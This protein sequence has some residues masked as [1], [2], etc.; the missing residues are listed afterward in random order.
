MQTL[1][2]WLPLLPWRRLSF[3]TSHALCFQAREKST[4]GRS[5]LRTPS[6]KAGDELRDPHSQAKAEPHAH[7]SSS[8]LLIQRPLVSR[9]LLGNSLAPSAAQPSVK[10]QSR[11]RG[12][13]GPLSLHGA[14]GLLGKRGLEHLSCCSSGPSDR[15]PTALG[16]ASVE[17]PSLQLLSKEAWGLA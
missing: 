13:V 1:A 8:P 2:G 6:P 14:L 7:V 11:P 12:K 16:L 4:L 17:T 9:S 10:G 5:S 3:P 15:A